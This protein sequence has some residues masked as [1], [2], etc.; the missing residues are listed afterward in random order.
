MNSLARRFLLIAAA[1][2]LAAGGFACE[3]LIA[4]DAASLN[5]ATALIRGDEMQ[6]TVNLL[7]SDTLEGRAAGSPGGRAAGAFIVEQLRK[8]KVKPAGEGGSFEQ[9]FNNG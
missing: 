3:R 2:V 9:L 6:Q 8:L 1:C 7:A 4:A 5:A